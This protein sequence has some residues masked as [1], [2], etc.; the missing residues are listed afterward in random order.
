MQYF[1]AVPVLFP[2]V[3]LFYSSHHTKSRVIGGGNCGLS[4]ALLII[5]HNE[6]CNPLL[7][8]SIVTMRKKTISNFLGS[9]QHQEIVETFKQFTKALPT[10]I[11]ACN[12]G[13][14]SELVLGCG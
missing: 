14:Y 11:W 3:A 13:I 8:S 5:S 6:K 10:H 12:S 7:T 9:R 1:L 4:D 2:E